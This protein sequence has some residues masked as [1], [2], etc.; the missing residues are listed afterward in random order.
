M[1]MRNILFAGATA[2]AFAAAAAAQT[3]TPP[4]TMG[5]ENPA[6]VPNTQ[7][8]EP[9]MPA[10]TKHHRHH[11]MNKSSSTESASE[12]AETE[13]LNEQQLQAQN[14]T[15]APGASGSMKGPSMQGPAPGSEPTQPSSGGST[16][17]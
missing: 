1:K 5:P 3:S 17:Q 7:T 13:K 2:L 15:P 8:G 14:A 12:K 6:A 11:A 10:A 4:R 9:T 16:P